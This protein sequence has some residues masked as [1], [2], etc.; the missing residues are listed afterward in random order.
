MDVYFVFMYFKIEWTAKGQGNDKRK[1]KIVPVLMFTSFPSVKTS[2]RMP[3]LL[4]LLFLEVVA[5]RCLFSHNFCIWS[6]G[7]NTVRFLKELHSLSL[8]S[9]SFPW[10]SFRLSPICASLSWPLYLCHCLARTYTTSVSTDSL[11]LILRRHETMEYIAMFNEGCLFFFFFS[12]LSCC[13]KEVTE[14]DK[15]SM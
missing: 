6:S 11:S 9:N 8:L 7:I 4:L 14:A 5:A 10:S 13:L 2:L 1:H 15:V 3:L 12:L